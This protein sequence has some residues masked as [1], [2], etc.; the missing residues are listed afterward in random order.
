MPKTKAAPSP[1]DQLQRLQSYGVETRPEGS[2]WIAQKG[3]CVATLESS[4]TGLRVVGEPEFRVGAELAKLL[5]GGYQKFLQ[6][7]TRKFPATADHLRQM[8]A[9]QDALST[10]LGSD[11]L[12]NLALGT[13]ST[14][15]HYDRVKGRANP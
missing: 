7:P 14:S 6:T 1:Q 12:Y 10:A 4:K 9:F 8:H 2:R 15:Y 3:S 5:D 13:V 11:N